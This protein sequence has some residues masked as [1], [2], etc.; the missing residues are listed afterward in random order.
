V[1]KGTG[2]NEVWQQRKLPMDCFADDHDRKLHSKA[3]PARRFRWVGDAFVLA[4]TGSQ[5]LVWL[6]KFVFSFALAADRF[7]QTRFF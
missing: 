5:L 6:Y 2:K 4:D 1:G 3:S 7:D